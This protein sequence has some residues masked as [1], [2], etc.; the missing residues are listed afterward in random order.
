[1]YCMSE[2]HVWEG[3][4]SLEDSVGSFNTTPSVTYTDS[5]SLSLF[6]SPFLLSFLPPVPSHTMF[7]SLSLTCAAL[8]HLRHLSID[9]T[10]VTDAG[11]LLIK[12]ETAIIELQPWCVL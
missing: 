9:N 10:L 3:V 8:S 6:L 11:L 7:L 5:L 12:G 1:M 4:F 2:C